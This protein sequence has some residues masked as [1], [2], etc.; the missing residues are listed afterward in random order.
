[1]PEQVGRDERITLP[2]G[3]RVLVRHYGRDGGHP[4][5]MLHGLPGSRLMFSALHG[6][7]LERGIHVVAP[8]RWAYG[9]SDAPPVPRLADYAH[10]IGTLMT[11]LGV[12]RFAVAGVS[13][14]GPYTA[15][16]A[17]GLADRVTA[18]GF[19]SP[20]GLIA[21][22][23]AAE[24][25]SGFHFFCFRTLPHYPRAIERVFAAYAAVIARGDM[26]ASRIATARAPAPDKDVMG[27]PATRARII[28]S[29]AEGL[30]A[31]TRG[32][33]IDLD[34]FRQIDRL[35]FS[36]ARMP[37]RVWIGTEDRN[38]P[39]DAAKRLAARLPRCELTVLDGAGH[40][41]IAHNFERILDWVLAT[42]TG[43]S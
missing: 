37:T 11:T 17:C 7:A 43:R 6:A 28:T 5:V 16:I 32:P 12:D 30:K 39:V 14:G 27:H 33:A 38:V 8:D 25:I 2:D 40:L 4:L 22:S 19:I 13:G 34:V 23:L 35:E 18:A 21:E 9:E 41:W 42:T 20:V 36:R 26:T 10:D 29:F 3:R 1:M 24:Q 15:A 31:S